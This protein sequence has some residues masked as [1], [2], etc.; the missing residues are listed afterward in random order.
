MADDFE[1]ADFGGVGHVRSYAGAGVV[2]SDADYSEGVRHVVREFAQVDDGSGLGQ[3]HEAD[4]HGQILR[5][6]LVDLVLYGLYLPVGGAGVQNVVALA[7]LALDVGVLR[8]GTA[9]HPHHRLVEDMF[10]CVHRSD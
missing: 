4:G 2:V 6:D 9:E 1:A 5:D 7:L 10:C 3:R 8:A